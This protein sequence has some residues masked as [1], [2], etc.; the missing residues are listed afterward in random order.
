MK[1]RVV[2]MAASGEEFEAMMAAAGVTSGDV[3]CSDDE[4]T[5]PDTYNFIFNIDEDR[6]EIAKIYLQNLLKI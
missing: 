1:T 5:M 3:E 2:A 6:I 4:T